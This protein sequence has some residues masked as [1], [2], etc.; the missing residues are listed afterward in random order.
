MLR[1]SERCGYLGIIWTAISDSDCVLL[2]SGSLCESS[3]VES[4]DSSDRTQPPCHHPGSRRAADG[5]TR[6]RAFG[7]AL[8]TSGRVMAGPGVGPRE[9]VVW[10]PGEG[11]G[12]GWG[13]SE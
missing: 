5:K 12:G 10:G 3:S 11:V 9:S 13:P 1:N 7:P 6:V 4:I 2:L 8:P